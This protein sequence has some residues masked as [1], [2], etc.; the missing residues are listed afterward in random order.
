MN[1]VFVGGVAVAA[2]GV[3]VCAVAWPAWSV[4]HSRE[5]DDRSPPT[6]G[7]IW[8][9]RVVGVGMILIGACGVYASLTGM[10]DAQGPP[11]P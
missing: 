5:D 1:R 9:M 11:L 7:E 2:I 3:G 10:P 4:L 6:V 8:F